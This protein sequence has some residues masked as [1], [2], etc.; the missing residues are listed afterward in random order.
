MRIATL[1]SVGGAVGLKSGALAAPYDQV[2]AKG[3]RWVTTDGPDACPSKD[4]LRQIIKPP[5]R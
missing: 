5:C 3:Y 1:V 4:D 2:A